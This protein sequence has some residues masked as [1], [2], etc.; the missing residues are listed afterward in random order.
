MEPYPAPQPCQLVGRK[1]RRLQSS[2]CHHSSTFRGSLS[3][4]HSFVTGC[5]S[6]DQGRHRGCPQGVYRPAI[7]GHS[8]HPV[9]YRLRGKWE[10]GRGVGGAGA[11]AAPS[12]GVFAADCQSCVFHDLLEFAILQASSPG[13]EG[14]SQLLPGPQ[15][16]PPGPL[17][18]PRTAAGSRRDAY[19]RGGPA[20][21]SLGRRPVPIGIAGRR[22]ATEPGQSRLGWSEAG[23]AAA[24][25]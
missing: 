6:T 17:A 11:G 13:A 1:C 5:Y 14:H 24:A 23:G 19:G 7:G 21:A 10:W 22:A 20:L 9:W 3:L 8:Y 15:G 16:R 2:Y 4:T 25:P 12:A 18:A